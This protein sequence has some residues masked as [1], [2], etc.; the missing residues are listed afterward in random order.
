[1]RNLNI[2]P[3]I[4]GILL[5]L[6]F[7]AS[8]T[9]RAF[10][11]VIIEGY[12]TD[13]VTGE[14]LQAANVFVVGTSLG[15]ASDAQGKY[16]IPNVPAGEYTLRVSYIG[17]SNQDVSIHVT[18]D[19]VVKQNF[20][21]HYETIIGEGV[22][23]TAQAQGQIAAINQQLTAKS[24]V[25]V[26]SSARIQE[27]PDANAA[28]SIGRLP[29]VS[30]TRVGGEGTKV[31]I[32]GLEPKYNLIKINGI[33]MASSNSEDRGTDLSMISPDMLESIEVSKTTTA[34]QDADVFGGTVNFKMRKAKSSDSGRPGMG[35]NFLAQGGYNGLSNAYDKYRNYKFVSSFE[36][37]FFKSLF[38]VFVQANFERKN[39]SSN[40]FRASYSHKSADEVNYITQSINLHTIPRDRQR[41]NG[42]L[43]LDLE[44]PEGRIDFSN[45][46]SSGITEV[47]DRYENLSI[48]GNQHQYGI[49]YKK[50]TLNMI[51]NALHFEGQLPLVHADMKLTHSYS[52][53]KN[54]RDWKVNFYQVPAGINQFTNK[55]NLDPKVVAAAVLFNAKKTKLNTISTTESLAKERAW[56]G[57]ID[58]DFN[59]NFSD[60]ISSVIKFGGKYRHQKRSYQ[61]E[62]YDTNGSLVSPS[63]QGAT[64][65]IV[66]HFKIPTNDPMAIPLAYYIDANYSYGRFLNG[67]YK[68]H[69]AADFKKISDLI[70]YCSDNV[71]VFAKRG[72]QG[73]YSRNNYLS[74]THNY[75]GKEIMTAAY[76]MATINI[77]EALT[78]IPGIRYQNLET[79]YSGIRGQ[80]SP[81]SWYRYYHP[82][83]TT[84]TVKHPYWLPNL[85]VRYKPLSW[86]DVRLAYSNTISYP[87]FISIIPR[88]DATTGANLAWN[89]YNLKPSESQNYDLYFTVSTNEI[90]LFTVGGFLKK[91]SNLI[92]PWTFNK[93]GLEANPYYLPSKN[94]ATHITYNIS[95]YI[96]NPYVVD[97]YGLELDWQTHFWYLPAPFNGLVFNANYTHVYSKAKYPYVLAG[98]TTSMNVDTSF[99][100]RLIHQPNH[101][102]N[103]SLGYDYKDFSIRLSMLYQDD[104][105]TGI[106]QWP[107]LRSTTAAYQRWDISVKQKLPWFNLELYGNVNNLN[108]ALD[109]SMLQMYSRIP[110][111]LEMYGMSADAGIRWRM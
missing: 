48:S 5:F 28:E 13:V 19:A 4:C 24:I 88:I 104:V 60:K 111:V 61:S 43:V 58:L 75:S 68:M 78:L 108:G 85:N 41:L 20:K 34:D 44:L 100:D 81:I 38:G 90:G 57:S 99:T 63:S 53:T 55:E 27:L 107:Q 39:L 16:R 23:V 74:T 18:G 86:F 7:I 29:G 46:Y 15:A 49:D 102:V 87:D 103:L 89:N 37:R 110:R 95:T 36:G 17:Y 22:T 109:R 26:V 84:V 51:S 50:T 3:K 42:A 71:N 79:I 21:L 65:L 54:P 70:D 69:H 64:R 92:Y 93:P 33:R 62:V 2:S 101:I 106:N 1:M 77:G 45:F 47:Q 30:I 10:S 35:L 97:N 31:V 91:I 25:N 9:S 76:L 67:D 12:I 32:R 40:E 83:D 56:M 52:E 66:S 80:Q 98:A 82:D 73:A 6:V 11:A 94:P 8:N 59:L 96:N 72:S 105:F 14:P